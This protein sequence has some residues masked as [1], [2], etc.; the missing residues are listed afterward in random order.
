M[1]RLVMHTILRVMGLIGL[2]VLGWV[3][4]GIGQ[5]VIT[6]PAAPPPAS[7]GDALTLPFTV[8]NISP[9]RDIFDFSL[10]VSLGLEPLGVPDPIELDPNAEE[11]VFVSV[12]VSIK[13][14]AGAGFVTL[15]ARSRKNP[16]LTAQANVTITVKESPGL[17]L[18]APPTK[19][20]ELGSTE[21]IVFFVRNKGNVPD[22]VA[23]SVQTTGALRAHVPPG[24]ISL[25][26]GER[27]EILIEV[28]IPK[29]A[30]PVRHRVILR[31][32]SK[33]FEGV[34]A[35]ATAVLEVLP[36]LPQDVGGSLFL[37][38][39]SQLGFQLD[40]Q[41][42]FPVGASVAIRESGGA[43]LPDRPAVRLSVGGTLTIDNTSAGAITV[44][45]SDGRSPVVIPP[46]ASDSL[47]FALSGIFTVTVSNGTLLSSVMI[48]TVQDLA[49]RQTL[50][51]TGQF[52]ARSVEFKAPESRP[53]HVELRIPDRVR[54][55]T[56]E[57]RVA[58]TLDIQ[59]LFE[60][61]TLF[62]T[63]DVS[64]L[65]FALGDLS[66]PINSLATLFGR[67][68]QITLRPGFFST[69]FSLAA[70]AAQ[71]ALVEVEFLITDDPTDLPA[72]ATV[73]LNQPV[74]FR[75]AG[76]TPHTVTI[77][78]S[79]SI[80]LAPGQSF[81]HVFSAVGQI[82]VTIDI[83]P[84]VFTVIAE[85]FCSA[86][87]LFCV[88]A[89]GQGSF[90]PGV[91]IGQGALLGFT[92]SSVTTT[93]LSKIRW[94]IPGGSATTVEGG[95]TV[96]NGTFLDSALRVA[97]EL[98]IGDF[99]I[100]AQF[101]RAGRDFVGDRRDAQGI[102]VFQMFS[103]T[104]FSLGLGFERTHNNV[105]GDPL[106]QTLT[107]QDARAF[108]SL[109]LSE[110]LPTLRLS[111]AYS[112]FVSVGPLPPT[113]LSR[114]AFTAQL[115][116][117][118]GTLGDISVFTEQALLA[119]ALAGTETGFG[120]V[121][122]EFSI[123]LPQLRA[124]L[125]F[126]HR[127]E[128]DLLTGTL[129]SQSLVTSAGIELLRRPFG[130]RFG[131]TRFPDRFGLSAALQARLGI[132]SLFFSGLSDFLDSGSREF[133]FA[134]AV[135]F[136]FDATIPFIVVSGRVEGFVFLDTNSNGQR[137]PNEAGPKNLILT[138]GNEKARTD[139]RGFFRFP[140]MDPGIYELK[141]EKL[142]TGIVVKTELP[143]K[144]Q[145]IAGKTLKLEIPLAQ[146][147]VIEG[148]VFHDE[149][150][151]GQIDSGE[152]GLGAVRVFLTDAAGKTRDQRT[153][154]DGRFAFSE[155]LPGRYTVALDVRSLPKDFVP[156]TPAE[157]TVELKA[158][159]RI[160]V[161]FG[162]AER[163]RTVKFPPVAQFEFTPERPKVGETVRFDA[164]ESFDPDGHIIKYAWDF[165]SDGTIDAQGVR[166]EHIFTQAGT[167][168]VTLTV[169]DNDGETGTARKT[170]TIGTRLRDPPQ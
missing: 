38:I 5:V 1:P 55:H 153:D 48:V 88:G 103:T 13:A 57:N 50:S 98:R 154:L 26:V 148:F 123:K 87:F 37:T 145:I 19:T 23:F 114:F 158:Q 20:V 116:Q 63:L 66:L 139:E 138:L 80:T 77:P 82:T 72:S 136:Q 141:I 164:S 156:T 56:E 53:F 44:T 93:L 76:L 39:P 54:S 75:N 125:G 91:T 101:L 106:Q 25:D 69:R 140:P 165:Q 15:K 151:N 149:N 2:S 33:K 134:L 51:G 126:A 144:V 3:W 160:T 104:N 147:A 7:P 85:A 169:T 132:A 135:A 59:N 28:S 74:R 89:E 61:N 168:T 40:G 24:E 21:T 100:S 111:T 146:V 34:S 58:Y 8:K 95:L 81:V 68:G 159:E 9:E 143:Q 130:V 102:A 96:Q 64:P 92:S 152:Q 128:T 133:S 29:G 117:P 94:Q 10:E 105:T 129:L 70:V 32:V 35:E 30:P 16:S 18:I 65:G 42:S 137:D 79:G 170:I 41:T 52:H 46:G 110:I 121:G 161:N 107:R 43:L 150:R 67:G 83:T 47:V 49:F 115:I 17:E 122:S 131:W 60:L 157:A 124:S 84:V 108:F 163:P 120:T 113:D 112:T 31:A 97:S 90:L 6:P 73:S 12:F 127:S 36:P 166:V 14:R 99:A 155:L 162:A 45:V 78:G 86:S 167:F 22:R 118:I 4:V 27:R 142:P 71:R 109:K 11:T 62:F 119:N